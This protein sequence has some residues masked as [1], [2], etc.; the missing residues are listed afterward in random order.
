MARFRKGQSGNPA[1]RPRGLPNKVTRHIRTLV[2][3]LLDDDYFAR[4]RRRLHAGKLPPQLEQLLWHYR[5][6]RPT[7]TVAVEPASPVAPLVISGTLPDGD[8][9]PLDVAMPGFGNFHREPDGSFSFKRTGPLPPALP[10]GTD[11]LDDGE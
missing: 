10:G 2:A 5:F 11:D 6:G 3:D 1:G 8:V 4:F 9:G 7:Y